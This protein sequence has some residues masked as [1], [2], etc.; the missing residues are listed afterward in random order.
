MMKADFKRV[1]ALY[2]CF[3]ILEFLSKEKKPLGI[4]EISSALNLNKSTVFNIVYTLTDLGVLENS[5]NRFRFGPKLYVLGKAAENGSELIRIIHPYLVE[6]NEKTHLSAFLGMRSGATAIILDKAES[7]F[8]LKVSSEI[9]IRIPLLAGA[10]G[11]ALLSLESDDEINELLSQN[12]LKRFTRYSC[13]DK[14]KYWDL[15]R[16]VRK[17]HIAVENET[18]IE[19]IRALAVPLRLKRRD[20]QMAIWAVG[21]KPQIKDKL[22][23]S[24]SSLLKEI[25]NK[26]EMQYSF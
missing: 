10:H 21:L 23:A 1:P 19:G 24:F 14:K 5:D 3:D 6:I 13:M 12:E 4:S 20:L 11:Q 16:K 2:K 25:A 7:A 18:Y 17:E 9:G 26:I 22:V 8:D 15:I